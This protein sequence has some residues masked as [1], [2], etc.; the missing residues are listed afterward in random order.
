MPELILFLVI[1]LPIAWLVS[2]F[3]DNRVARI[4]LGTSAIAMSIG[5]AYGVGKLD[6]LQSNVYFSTATKDLIQN[7]IIEL[8]NGRPDIVLTEL[9]TLRDDFQPTYETRDDYDVLVDRYIHAISDSPVQ[10][11]SGIPYW[12][13]EMEDQPH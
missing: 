3:K 1:A 10:H 2:E 7:T 8:E 12:S 6:R 4:A 9:R 5:V 13:H 11:K